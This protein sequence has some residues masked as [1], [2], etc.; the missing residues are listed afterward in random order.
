MRER[1]SKEYKVTVGKL[2]YS[3]EDWKAAESEMRS[4]T[5]REPGRLGGII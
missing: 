3:S 5:S 1:A 2:S 4:L